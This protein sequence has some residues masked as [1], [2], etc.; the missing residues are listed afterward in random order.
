MKNIATIILS[1][2]LAASIIG[3]VVLYKQQ[4][5]TKEALQSSEKKASDLNERVK[6]LTAES[7]L[8]RNQIR[9]LEE[10]L[11]K[12]EESARSIETEFSSKDI[13]I[14]ELEKEKA[15]FEKEL[16]ELRADYE[17]LIADLKEL[18]RTRERLSAL[19]KEL[20]EKDQRLRR[21]EEKLQMLERQYSEEKEANNALKAQLLEKGKMISGL[22]EKIKMS[23]EAAKALEGQIAESNASIQALKNRID[24]LGQE[25]SV[26]QKRAHELETKY[27]ALLAD[28]RNE[29]EMAKNRLKNMEEDFENLRSAYET[30]VKDLMELKK[31][32]EQL[33]QL[34]K[35][36]VLK[37][38]ALSELNEKLQ[39][40]VR[41]YQR[42]KAI[43]DDLKKDLSTKGTLVKALQDKLQSSQA[44]LLQLEQEINKC[45]Y[46]I[47]GIQERLAG[48]NRERSLAEKKVA[49]LQ[50][51]YESLLADIDELERARSRIHELER[52]LQTKNEMVAGLEQAV[53]SSKEEIARLNSVI[54]G[55]KITIDRLKRQQMELLQ[56]TELT[57]TELDRMKSTYD[58]LI[59]DLKQ[60]ITNKE[61]TIEKFQKRISVTF[62]DRILFDFGKAS[63]SPEGR[64]VLKKVGNILKGVKD[65]TIRVV[66]HTDDVP[67]SPEFRWKFPS[68]WELSAARAASVVRY[69]Q[70]EIGLDPRNL[71]AVGRAFY[72]PV[73]SNDTPEGRAQ[74][75]RVN[76]IIGPKFR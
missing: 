18:K 29:L 25:K 19:E 1:V 53:R 7:A 49:A 16:S 72:D 24:Q 70:K 6:Q 31:A 39:G 76:I 20:D 46:D 26:A 68:N 3:G 62:V 11:K 17:T 67:I 8:L 38:Q 13:R 61:V 45:K 22:Q 75:R 47:S 66:G 42:E 64:S 10:S 15:R 28:N 60:Q 9:E 21:L 63:I 50:A 52:L 51:K 71:E 43:N 59:S 34:E 4:A 69:F 14:A 41:Q 44:K 56:E 73:A 35:S 40:L 58:A 57:K 12:T 54:S 5:D 32:K 55:D 36:I 65:R 74:N 48:L 23:D 2:V 37:D 30:L 33:P 27:Q